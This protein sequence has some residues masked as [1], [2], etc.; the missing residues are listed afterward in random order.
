MHAGMDLEPQAVQQQQPLQP[1][2]QQPLQPQQHVRSSGIVYDT[3]S[4]A[5]LDEVRGR[6]ESMIRMLQD[7]INSEFANAPA[8]P[9]LPPSSNW[10]SYVRETWGSLAYISGMI[11]A[12]ERD[13]QV[14]SHTLVH[15]SLAIV[16]DPV[17]VPEG[18]TTCTCSTSITTPTAAWVGSAMT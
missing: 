16:G 14:L 9:H 18:S 1:E 10:N 8:A 7:L 5:S 3:A 17:I 4:I 12:I 11:A 15:P 13:C 2:P 6:A